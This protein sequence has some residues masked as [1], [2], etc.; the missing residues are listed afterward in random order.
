[1]AQEVTA[2]FQELRSLADRH[3]ELHAD[4][5]QLEA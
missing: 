4:R 3:A 5:T 1:M 2:M